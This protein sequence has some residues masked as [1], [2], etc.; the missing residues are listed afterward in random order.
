[1]KHELELAEE[2]LEKVQE[3]CKSLKEDYLTAKEEKDELL[4]ENNARLDQLE[5]TEE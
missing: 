5:E 2:Q 4:A 1:M 3:Q